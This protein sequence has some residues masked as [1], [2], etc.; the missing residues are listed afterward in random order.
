MKFKIFIFIL[1]SIIVSSVNGQNHHLTE[2]ENNLYWQPDVKINFSHFQSESDADCIKYNEK[3]GVKMSPN[4]QLKGVVDIPKS[5]LSRRIKKRAGNDKA[6]LAPVFCKNCSCI[7]SED[8]IE[9]KVYQLL[10]DVAEMCARGARKELIQTQEQMNVNNVN[11]MFFTTIRNRWDRKMR[12]IWASIIQDV[13]IQK[14]RKWIC[15]ME[16]IGK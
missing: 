9:L 15:G 7:L 13:L 16:K 5:H 4:I 8:S 6:Y 10:F 12:G 3:Y 11:T 1:F 14:K 2:D